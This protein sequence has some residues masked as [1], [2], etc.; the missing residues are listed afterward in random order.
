MLNMKMYTCSEDGDS[1]HDGGDN[2][3]DDGDDDS[4]DYNHENY[5]ENNHGCDYGE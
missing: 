2:S 5:Y 3:F 1:F 4:F